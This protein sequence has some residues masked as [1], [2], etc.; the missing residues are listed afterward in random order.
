MTYGTNF[1]YPTL[2]QRI[3]SI[4]VNSTDEFSTTFDP[5]K[6]HSSE[7]GLELSGVVNGDTPLDGWKLTTNL[8]QNVYDNK[9]RATYILGSPIPLFENVSREKI[10]GLEI[11]SDSFFFEK[12]V[13]LG[14]GVSK[15]FISDKSAFPFKH[16]FKVTSDLVLNFSGLSINV[17][18]FKEGDQ[19]GWI[20][21]ESDL[22]TEITLPSYSNVDFHLTKRFGWRNFNLVSNISTLNLVGND[23]NIVG[24]ALRDRRS[25]LSIGLEY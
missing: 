7:M 9:I 25:Y 13:N 4:F 1:K 15:Y 20:K 22:L 10:S 3:S 5:E 12:K 18:L 19:I 24:L 11:N 16:E 6:V 8:F 17:I 23:L 2:F 21:D 14:F